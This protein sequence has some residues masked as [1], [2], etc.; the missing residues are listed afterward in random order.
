MTTTLSLIT[1]QVSWG[2][3]L[4]WSLVLKSY[5]PKSDVTMISLLDYIR[6]RCSRLCQGTKKQIS[7]QKVFCEASPNGL[8]ASADCLRGG[9]HGNVSSGKS[10]TNACLMYIWTPLSWTPSFTPKCKQSLLFLFIY[11]SWKE[12]TKLMSSCHFPTSLDNFFFQK[13]NF[14]SQGEKKTTTQYSH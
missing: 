4:E 8:P 14:I 6:R 12:K 5:C 7:N 13:L 1:K 11:V 9:Q 3:R 10:R 2:R